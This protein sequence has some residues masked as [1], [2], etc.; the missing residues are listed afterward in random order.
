M[1]ANLRS[2]ITDASEGLLPWLRK[3]QWASHAVVIGA[4]LCLCITP[5]TLVTQTIGLFAGPVTHAFGWTRTQFFLGPS[6]ASAISGGFIFALGQLGDRLGIRPILLI[7]AMLYGSS[8]MSMALLRRSLPVYLALCSATFLAGMT[9]SSLLYA[10]AI[11]ASFTDRR[12]LM[13]S[14]A[15]SGTGVGSILIPLFASALIERIGWR[16]AYVGL[17]ALVMIIALPSIFFLVQEPTQKRISEPTGSPALTEG[18][19]LGE[20]VRTRTFWLLI[21]LF[22]IS[23]AALAALVINFVPILTDRG[24]ALPAAASAMSALGASQTLTRLLSGYVL[25]RTSY[26]RIATVWYVLATAGV[27]ILCDAYT[28]STAIVAGLLVGTAWGAENHLAAYFTGRYFGLRSYGIILGT[29][30]SAFGLVATPAV[31]LTA[32]MYDIYGNYNVALAVITGCLG[33]SCV[34]AAFLG[35][36]RFTKTVACA[37]SDGS[38]AS[39]PV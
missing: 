11:S 24:I 34:L 9:Q 20:A 1:L 15:M 10:K 8:L 19:S 17:G 2:N 30:F 16:G 3:P 31:L 36:Y 12:A 5:V 23:N 33:F 21:S 25:D 13:L 35:P 22:T 26:A 28:P 4:F 38:G 6:I 39:E 14:I 29:I 18:L 7:G 27:A 37:S 32:H